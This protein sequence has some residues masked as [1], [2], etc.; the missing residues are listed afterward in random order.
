MRIA[1]ICPISLEGFSGASQRIRRL[2]SFLNQKSEFHFISLGKDAVRPAGLEC[3]SFHPITSKRFPSYLNPLGLSARKLRVI[4]CNRLGFTKGVDF[5]FDESWGPQLRKLS[6]KFNFDGV[7]SEYVFSSKAL[8]YFRDSNAAIDTIDVFYRRVGFEGEK[9][10]NWFECRTAKSESVGW[11]RADT[12]FGIQQSE[13]DM[14]RGLLPGKEV[15]TLGHLLETNFCYSPEVENRIG[16]IAS[17]SYNNRV[18]IVRFIE[19]PF[20]EIQSIQPQTK[21]VVAGGVCPLLEDAPNVEKLGY[22]N[23]LEDFYSNISFAINPIIEGTGL[24]IKTIEAIEHGCPILTTPVGIEGIESLQCLGV[25]VCD[26]DDSWTQNAVD[27]LR[28]MDARNQSSAS[29]QKEATNY[30]EI[31]VRTINQWLDLIGK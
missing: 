2:A 20:S 6:R 17:G 27:L 8:S 18:A 14:I 24:K 5:W 31:V 9:T 12:V 19:G 10:S 22:V 13:S 7:I 29:A 1:I 30:G 4:C 28:S 16:V 25:R 23:S 11:A 3:H 26:T 21:L 15:L